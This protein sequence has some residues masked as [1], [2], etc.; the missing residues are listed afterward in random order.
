MLY[1]I[2][3]WYQQNKW[4]E[5]EQIWYERRMHTEF[6]DTVKQ[7]QLFHRSKACRYQIILLGYAPNFR[8]FLHRQSVYRAPYWSCFDAIQEVKRRRAAALSFHQLKW[9]DGIEFRYT[10]FVV[11][12]VLEGQKYAQIDFGEDG[13]PIQVSLY[14]DDKICRRN[15]YDDRGFL[16]ATILYENEQPVHCDYL[17]ENGVWTLRYFYQD[18]HVEINS[19]YPAYLLRDQ[20]REEERRFSRLR[21]DDIS[22][23]I[24][25][26][27]LFYLQ[28]VEG[29]DI[30]CVAM[31]EQ[32]TR[33][34]EKV[35]R[36]KKLILSF[37]SGRSLDT[38]SH[39]VRKMVKE[40]DYIV[41]DSGNTLNKLKKVWKGFM[42]NSM[43]IPPYD[44]RE[45]SG[46]SLQFNV[47][48]VLVAIDGVEGEGFGKLVRTLGEYLRINENVQICLL[49]RKTDY[50]RKQRV[51][52]AVRKELLKAGMEDGWAK[53]ADETI[54]ENNINME[55]SV[56]VKFVVEQCVDE[57]SVSKCMREQ[58]LFVDLREIPELYLQITAIS[59]G[60][61][62]IV[63]TKTEFVTDGLNGK[64]LK[65]VHGLPKALH[66]Y[67]GGLKN[68]N[69]AR[70]FSYELMKEYTT[71][72]LLER[73]KE[74]M[75][76][77][78][79]DLYF[80]IGERRLE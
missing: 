69:Q 5:H 49:T 8:H 29:E 9:P 37:F 71:D 72:K 18:G 55:E 78:G 20:G 75:D 26:V 54:S 46:L 23:V 14:K 34:L 19:K 60:I 79:G 16:S 42:K 67:L 51:L 41:A 52:E 2:P 15:L 80:T 1:F 32:H 11:T 45:D 39:A 47:Q 12:A 25:E 7:I 10:L 50:D 61:P 66:Y 53:E 43:A 68:W 73:W 35:L 6:D 58:R 21:Y 13:N 57:L 65:N 63:R 74:V 64:I 28:M 59:I 56:A 77:V 4:S 48:K 36:N 76:S 38:G 62:Q 3:A 70:V 44:S 33:L 17:M 40:A 27:L 24:C 31:H 22:Q 30:F